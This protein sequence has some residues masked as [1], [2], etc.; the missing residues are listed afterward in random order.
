MMIIYNS[1]FPSSCLYHLP[2]ITYT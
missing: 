1:Y 2:F